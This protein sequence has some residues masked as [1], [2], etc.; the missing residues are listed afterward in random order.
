MWNW[1]ERPAWK[2]LGRGAEIVITDFLLAVLIILCLSA[3]SY[4]LKASW[5]GISQDHQMFIGKVHVWYCVA[6]LVIFPIKSIFS[7]LRPEEH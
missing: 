2:S 5:L 3:V 1:L 7:I 6:L 4:L